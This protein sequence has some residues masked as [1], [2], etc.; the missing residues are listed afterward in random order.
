MDSTPGCS[1]ILKLVEFNL[2]H[3]NLGGHTEQSIAKDYESLFLFFYS[4]CDYS[5]HT[6]LVKFLGQNVVNT[7]HPGSGGH[8]WVR[9]W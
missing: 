9:G 4:A 5:K 7:N 3:M 6:D 8:T 1:H 2:Q